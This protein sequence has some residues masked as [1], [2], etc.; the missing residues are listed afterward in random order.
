MTY[1][2]TSCKTGDNVLEL[3]EQIASDLVRQHHPKIVGHC[4]ALLVFDCVSFSDAARIPPAC[5][6]QLCIQLSNGIFRSERPARARDTCAVQ[7][8]VQEEA[9]LI[10]GVILRID[11]QAR[12]IQSMAF[13]LL[14]S[15]EKNDPILI[16]N[17]VL[18]S[19]PYTFI[20][21]FFSN[22]GSDLR[23]GFI[24]QRVD[25]IS[26]HRFLSAFT[27]AEVRVSAYESVSMLTLSTNVQICT[28]TE[29]S[30]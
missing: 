29:R 4:I 7:G 20:A 17:S 26:A 3:F 8:E 13:S 28:Q 9:S 23:C 14:L 15:S 12:T 25:S 2:E 22:T 27:H 11:R 6:G 5:V 1:F 19:D 21:I 30:Y 10:F 24:N 16:V 18:T